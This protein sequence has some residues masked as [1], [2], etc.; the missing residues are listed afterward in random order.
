MKKV[1]FDETRKVRAREEAREEWSLGDIRL[2]ILT[3]CILSLVAIMLVMIGQQAIAT[4]KIFFRKVALRTNQK[5]ADLI[6][7][8]FAQVFSNTTG[9]LEDMSHFPT[10]VGQKHELCNYLFELILKRHSIF[11]A[12]YVLD[13]D[14]LAA[15]RSR[16]EK[17]EGKPWEW[18]NTN[19]RTYRPL[20]KELITELESGWVPSRLTEYYSVEGQP[21][22]TYVCSI[23]D[24]RSDEVIGLLGAELKLEFIQ[25]V[26]DGA[27]LG[28][29]GDVLVVDGK[30]SIIFSTRGFEEVEDFNENFPVERA[31][32]EK[33]GG[34]EYRGNVSKLAAYTRIQRVTTRP[35]MPTLP[36]SP[37]PSNITPREIPDWLIVVLQDAAEGYMVAN[38]LKWN[39]LILLLIGAIGVFII[40]KLWMD[41]LQ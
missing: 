9:L 15:G 7:Q 29:T 32:R 2:T 30:G 26:I 23:R 5:L 20:T 25:P 39:I 16:P 10:V 6:S 4:E 24:P 14:D 13:A 31:Y 8:Q 28:K 33:K 36:T 19:V 12:I 27:E 37:F 1:D 41:S 40:G 17:E 21:A 22:I 35:F 3:C 34:V 38:R 18:Y 11:R